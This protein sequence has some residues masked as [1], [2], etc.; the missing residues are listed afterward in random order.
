MIMDEREIRITH[1]HHDVTH[2]FVDCCLKFGILAIAYL[3]LWSPPSWLFATSSDN[4]T[5]KIHWLGL[6]NKTT[7]L[8]L[9]KI[10]WF[11][12]T[13]QRDNIAT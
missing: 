7:W 12:V 11:D 8:R 3:G 6:G 1:S 10:S 5:N 9:E 4:D 13:T 2:C